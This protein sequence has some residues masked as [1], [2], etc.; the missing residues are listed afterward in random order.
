MELTN[1]V[2]TL[3]KLAEISYQ[4]HCRFCVNNILEQRH[5]KGVWKGRT[6][7]D[8][9]STADSGGVCGQPAPLRWT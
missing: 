4:C 8:G 6:A 9:F 3:L 1:F 5:K 2:K 7:G